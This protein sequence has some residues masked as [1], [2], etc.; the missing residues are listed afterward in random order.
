MELPAAMR[1]TDPG[2]DGRDDVMTRL[3]RIDA[4]VRVVFWLAVTATVGLVGLVLWQGWR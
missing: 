3:D 1:G 2:H 4:V